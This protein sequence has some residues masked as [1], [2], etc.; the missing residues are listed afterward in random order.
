MTQPSPLSPPLILV[1]GCFHTN[2]RA[3]PQASAVAIQD[4][5]FLAVGD[6]DEVMRHRAPD[7][8]V[9]DLNGRTAIP[10]LNDSHIHLIRGG[11]N[12][13]LELRWE[14]VPSLAD[15]LRML[16]EQAL[17]TPNPQWVR[18]VGGW[19]EF[20]F[21]EKRM[22]TIE[23]INAAAPDTPVFVL[24]LYDR[25]LLNR[26]ALRAV[27]YGKDTPNPPGGEIVRD[28]SGNPTGMLIARPNAMIL[29]A[30]LAKGPALP[31]ELQVNSTRQFMR[32]LNRLGVTSV[33]DAG[34]GFQNYPEDYSVIEEL[35]RESQLTV[36]VAYNLFTQNKGKELGDFQNWT[37]TVELHQGNDW[38]RHN[39]AGEMLVFSAADFEDF[40]QPRPDLPET[41]EDELEKVVRHLVTQRW[42]FRLHATYNESIER[43]LD[44]FEKVDRDI[45][46]D[47]LHWL[48][49][50][51]ETITPK[52]I[53]RVRALGGGIAIQHRMAFQGEFF[54]ERYGAEAAKETP[55]IQR[56]LEAGVPVGAG[57]D[58]TRVASYNPWTALYWLV[59]G[60]TVG[61]LKLYDAGVR[62]SR[63]TAIALWTSGSAWF[64]NDQGKKGQIAEGMLADLSVL[65]A[66]FFRIDEEAIKDIE[67]VLTIVGGKL[68]FGQ[69]EFT[70][71]G[72][73]P[74]PVLP[75]WS[76]VNKVPGRYRAAPP[77]A[78]AALPHQCRSACGVHGH[79]HDRARKSP[80]PV[81]NVTGFWGALGCNCFAF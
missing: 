44:V 20:Q 81:S 15:A 64:S 41:M 67:S 56:M 54:V 12:Y 39:G 34:G 58:A 11:L 70:A 57:T 72:P 32:E 79:A 33:I 18:V 3:N 69:A 77:Q 24:H 9:I 38:Y 36:R 6:S 19:N 37:D 50:H 5:R 23:E 55:P 76:P 27:G 47:G 29:Y 43:M 65:S 8:Q 35:A 7:S 31:R 16:K 14:G 40:L 59:S 73:P 74:I 22:P 21:A 17:R 46:F 45:P 51:A 13:N 1:N 78:A 60:R 28:A 2:D 66:D 48:F 49:D 53:D 68:V 62:L 52:N 71:L 75:D 30:T 10:G 25:A 26:A 80:V 61:G 42:P 63:D 4:G